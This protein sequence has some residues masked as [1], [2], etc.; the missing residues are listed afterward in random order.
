MYDRIGERYRLEDDGV[1]WIAER[2]AGRRALEPDRRRNLT[3]EDLIDLFTVVRVQPDDA[4]E[5][6]LVP[7]RRVQ[8]IRSGFYRS[9][10]D[11]E[12]RELA[13][14]NKDF[15]KSDELRKNINSLGYEVKDL[16]NGYKINK[17]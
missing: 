17:I 11:A 5:A 14:K 7:G 9:R 10:V 12:E 13:R 16:P 3:S 4:T 15:K 8:D 6:L 1:V 2:V